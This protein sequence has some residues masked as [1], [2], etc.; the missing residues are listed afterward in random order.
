MIAGII[1]IAILLL[2][3]LCFGIGIENDSVIF[4]FIG[5]VLFS[6]GIFLLFA[7]I[8]VNADT[9]ENWLKI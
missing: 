8:G 4:S 1:I 6:F 3:G 5:I 7:F 2:G 9:I